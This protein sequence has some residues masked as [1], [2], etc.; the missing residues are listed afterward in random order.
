M[1]GKLL[2]AHTVTARIDGKILALDEAEPPELFKER[3]MMRRIAWSCV[4]AT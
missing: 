3:N 2:D 1:W 4:Q